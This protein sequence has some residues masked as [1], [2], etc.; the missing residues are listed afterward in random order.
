[1]R[2]Y[3][4][5]LPKALAT[6]AG[7]KLLSGALSDEQRD[8]IVRLTSYDIMQSVWEALS[9][10]TSDSQK[11]IDLIE[12]VRLHPTI[13]FPQSQTDK[14]TLANKRKV[15]AQISKLS[16]N[17]LVAFAE[18][19]PSSSDANNGIALL[20]YE[21]TRLQKEAV[22]QQRGD[23]LIHLHALQARLKAVDQDH[24][25]VET[26]QSLQDAAALAIKAPSDG[27]RKKGAQTASRTLFIKELKNYIYLNFGKKL[28]QAVAII[29]NT[30]MNLPPETVTEDLVRKA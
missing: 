24:G 21:L 11:L 14:L 4:I 25:I 8:C 17:L 30:A 23:T 2:T 12:Y 9:K 29:V 22:S 28:N 15:M 19:D 26:L 20:Q 7:Q 18:L 27:P 5:W 10:E 6:H 16:Q 13:F 3:P 1:M